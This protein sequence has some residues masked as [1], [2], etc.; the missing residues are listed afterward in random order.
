MA[1]EH[2]NGG[3]YAAVSGGQ[4]KGNE[5]AGAVP[6]IY[7]RFT[8]GSLQLEMRGPENFVERWLARCF[9]NLLPAEK[10]EKK[11]QAKGDLRAT[12]PRGRKRAGGRRRAPVPAAG[13]TEAAADVPVEQVATSTPEEAT[14][15]TAVQTPAAVPETTTGAGE[16]PSPRQLCQQAGIKRAVDLVS[17][18]VYYYTRFFGQ[19]PSA[20]QV[21]QVLEAIGN[22]AAVRSASTYLS[23]A[24]A[25]G[26]VYEQN[27]T[28]H[29]TDA[30]LEEVERRLGRAD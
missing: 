27:R 26:L 21:R 16:A 30:G 28:W 13:T 24:K 18:A 23:R 3:G 25:R 14:P 29:L 8:S 6:E 5:P 7:V 11:A 22:M 12:P 1:V 17:F 2:E 19:A 15:E 20:K 4:G 9:D 10:S